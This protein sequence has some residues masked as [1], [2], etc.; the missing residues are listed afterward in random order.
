VLFFVVFT[1]ALLGMVI[2]EALAGYSALSFLSQPIGVGLD[3]PLTVDLKVLRFTLG[4][5]VR[6]NLAVPIG[7]VIA[8]WI[9]RL[10]Q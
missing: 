3:P 9:L 1:G 5:V 7:I 8:V 6:L 4:A 10:L 2:A